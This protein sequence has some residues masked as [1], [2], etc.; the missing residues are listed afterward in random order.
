VRGT[1]R[2]AVA[3]VKVGTL[4]IYADALIGQ[5]TFRLHETTH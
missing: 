2:Q 4:L 3:S 5:L 1:Y